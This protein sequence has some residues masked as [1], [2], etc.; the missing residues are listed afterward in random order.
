MV[1]HYL[2]V[3]DRI[4]DGPFYTIM[5]DGRTTSI[6]RK[7]SDE[8]PTEIELFNAFSDNQ[9]W[10]SRYMKRHRRMPKLD[11]RPYAL[12]FFPSELHKIMGINISTKKRALAVD[13][14]VKKNLFDKKLDSLLKDAED[15]QA[16]AEEAEEEEE[17][18]EADPELEEKEDEDDEDNDDDNSS[19]A[20]D[21]SEDSDDDYNAEQYF[22][23]G[24]DDDLDDDP[25][26]NT[27]D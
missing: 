10:T 18:P 11:E 15:A 19:V 27:Y 4:H 12:E 13:I 6:K 2:A 14:T 8:A 1:Q 16:R 7:A 26:E 22:D 21:D 9:T 25:Y 3:R 5:N 24:E 17:E 20:S 23:N